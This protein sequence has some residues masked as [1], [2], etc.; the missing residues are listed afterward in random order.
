M[1]TIETLRSQQLVDAIQ[2]FSSGKNPFFGS[3]VIRFLLNIG[4][5]LSIQSNFILNIK[6]GIWTVLIEYQSLCSPKKKKKKKKKQT[7]QS[8][9]KATTCLA[10][11]INII[12]F[13]GESMGRIRF[14]KK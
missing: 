13:S 5:N 1:L 7:N 4:L 8:Y 10:N 12:Q 6:Y 11:L 3:S 14:N 2:L 9:D